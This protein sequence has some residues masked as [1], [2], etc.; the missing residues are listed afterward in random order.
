[1][2]INNTFPQQSPPNILI[3]VAAVAV[4]II[5]AIAAFIFGQSVGTDT[6]PEDSRLEEPAVTDP[7]KPDDGVACT[8]DVKLCP[9]GSGVGRVPPT[10]EFAPCPGE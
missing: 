3:I 5:M 1:M 6:L 7:A 9:D 4:A 10:C 2:A 8:M